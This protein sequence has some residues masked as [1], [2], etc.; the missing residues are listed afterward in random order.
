MQYTVIGHRYVH[1]E[2]SAKT[3]IRALQREKYPNRHMTYK[4]VGIDE[5]AGFKRLEIVILVSDRIGY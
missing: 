3:I 5:L 2:D 4:V 1:S